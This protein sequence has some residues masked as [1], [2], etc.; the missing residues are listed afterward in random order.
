MS[1]HE[2]PS[3]GLSPA[4]FQAWVMRSWGVW[5][6]HD[7]NPLCDLLVMGLGIGGEA[8]EVQELIKKK[9]RDGRDIRDDLRLELGDVLHYLTRIAGEFDLSLDEIMLANQMKIGA[10]LAAKL[11]AKHGTPVNES[12]GAP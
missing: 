4:E 5:P 3:A 7:N 2:T 1:D 8:G 11:A 10:R 12:A 6:C 9:V